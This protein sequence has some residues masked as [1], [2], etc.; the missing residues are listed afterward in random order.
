MQAQATWDDGHGQASQA[1]AAAALDAVINDG[2][3]GRPRELHE[4]TL[5][6]RGLGELSA[7]ALRVAVLAEPGPSSGGSAIIRAKS[8]A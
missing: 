4:A 3:P 2:F 8:N 7:G 1:A 6:C 5:L